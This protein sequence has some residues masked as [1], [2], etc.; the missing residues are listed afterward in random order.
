MQLP[1]TPENRMTLSIIIPCFNEERTIGDILRQ[2]LAVDLGPVRKDIIVV[3]DGSTDRSRTIA[4]EIARSA[5]ETVRVLVQPRNLGKGAAL[6]RGFHEARG[7]IVAIQDADLEYDPEDLSQMLALFRL[8]E[9][10]VVFGS[11]RLLKNPVSNRF[12]YSAV[13]LVTALSALL[14]QRRISDQFTCYKMLRRELVARLSLRE[15]GFV[16]DGELLAKLWRLGQTVYEVPITYHPRSR[17]E[18]KKVRLRDGF[19]WCWQLLKHRF[20]DPARW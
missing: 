8:P 16:V 6:Q 2:V 10:A 5:P 14:Y 13:P 18:G 4:E 1:Y 3:D 17:A 20:T 11:R 12:Y 19:L 7:E 9:V 15:R